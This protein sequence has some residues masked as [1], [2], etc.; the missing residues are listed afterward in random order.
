M[1]LRDKILLDLAEIKNPSALNQIFAFIQLLKEEH[2]VAQK[3]NKEGSFQLAGILSDEDAQEISAIIDAEFNA[4][5][6][7]AN[8]DIKL[9][10]G[11]QNKEISLPIK[12]LPLLRNLLKTETQIKKERRANLDLLASEAQKLKLGYE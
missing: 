10:I 1:S 11:N 5:E 12:V 3:V 7:T 6:D 9:K 2:I 4:L 8:Q